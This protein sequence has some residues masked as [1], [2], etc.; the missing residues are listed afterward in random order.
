MEELRKKVKKSL[1]DGQIE[2]FLGLR[3]DGGGISPFFVTKDNL[4][5]M[6]K[7]T[8]EGRYSLG[9]VL[10]LI[11]QRYPGKAIGVMVRGCD[12]RAIVEL[13]KASQISDRV[14]KFGVTCSAETAKSCKCSQPFPTTIDFGE[15]AQGF[16]NID[17]LNKLE[18]MKAEDRLSYWLEQFSKC[19]KCYGC[20]NICPMCYCTECAME[21]QDL[22]PGGIVPPAA[23]TF[24][25]IKAMHM[26]DR[27]IDCGLCEETCPA[28]QAKKIIEWE[29]PDPKGKSIDE[30][31][32][33]RD[34]LE[35]KVEM[36]LEE[37]ES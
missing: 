29:I 30:I 26:A 24:H 31:R 15:K 17:L 28:V 23:P 1:E 9:K 27:C 14:V 20:R 33:I 22:V 36:L 8:T 7:L 12:E 35:A 2:G 32:R 4:A 37:V 25:F 6:D 5:D 11:S 13:L 34:M 10:T 19:I 3:L 18:Q 16:D 21:D